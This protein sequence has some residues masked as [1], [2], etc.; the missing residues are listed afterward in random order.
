MQARAGALRA[1]AA[2]QLT[3]R[4]AA[5]GGEPFEPND[6]LLRLQRSI[7]NQAVAQLLRASVDGHAVHAPS[8]VMRATLIQ[9]CGPTPCNCSAAERAE[10]EGRPAKP[11]P[12]QCGVVSPDDM[13]SDAVAEVNNATDNSQVASNQGT[14]DDDETVAKQLPTWMPQP[15][16]RL[17]E[18]NVDGFRHPTAGGAATI[19]CD[20][21]GGYRVALNGWAGAPCGTEGCVVKH[22]SQ[23]AADWKKRWPD[24]CKPKADHPDGSD[25]PLGG[26]GYDAFLNDSECKA[27][28]VD[29]ACADDLLKTATGD[30][31]AKVQHYRDLTA[32]QKKAYC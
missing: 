16:P 18:A 2:Q 19:V 9:R 1:R 20:G 28:T 24:G 8:S 10:K 31:K 23:H 22:E 12:P 25:I 5:I 29:L 3:H 4:H 26:D 14:G 13:G 30:C 17:S 27:H 11:M 32:E 15:N 7:G 6:R 21:N